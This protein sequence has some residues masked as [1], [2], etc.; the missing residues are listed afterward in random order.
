MHKYLKRFNNQKI[1]AAIYIIQRLLTREE[2]RR[3]IID[4]EAL[5]LEYDENIDFLHIG[6]PT[7][8]K[9]NLIHQE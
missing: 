8:W 1:Y 6:F 7:N 4:L 3:F 2:S 5:I 9:E